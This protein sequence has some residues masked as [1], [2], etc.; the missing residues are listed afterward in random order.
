MRKSLIISL[1]FSLI[2]IPAAKSSI[3]ISEEALKAIAENTEARIEGLFDSQFVSGREIDF[4]ISLDKSSYNK[5]EAVTVNCQF[6]NTSDKV[7]YYNSCEDSI[8]F[9]VFCD[10]ETIIHLPGFNQLKRLEAVDKPVKTIVKDG[11][12]YRK[13]LSWKEEGLIEPC[14]MAAEFKPGEKIE[15]IFYINTERFWQDYYDNEKG[16][17]IP[18]Y[19]YNRFLLATIYLCGEGFWKESETSRLKIK[20]NLVQFEIHNP[21]IK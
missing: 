18:T 4:S 20:S 1:I 16:S 7:F 8:G 2:V 15:Q 5:G 13:S 14:V 21:D 11:T 10:N 19:F 3:W 12:L 9:A 17:V 6:E